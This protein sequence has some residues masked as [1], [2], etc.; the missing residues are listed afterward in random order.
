MEY[1]GCYLNRQNG[2]I[3][4]PQH[5]T[6]SFKGFYGGP[7]TS[8]ELC[9]LFGKIWGLNKNAGSRHCDG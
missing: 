8:D 3:C 6:S 4:Q 7:G 1:A 9:L 5:P 2:I